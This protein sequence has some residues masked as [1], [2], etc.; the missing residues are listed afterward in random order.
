LLKKILIVVKNDNTREFLMQALTYNGFRVLAAKDGAG[1]LYKL[2]VCQPHLVILEIGDWDTLDRFRN[3]T[4][5][6]IIALTPDDDES[7]VESLDRGAD[8]FVTQPPSFGELA[9][10]IRA[11]LRRYETGALLIGGEY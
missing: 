2:G 5:A 1:G 8:F 4:A 6:P 3:L 11:L 7:G 10:R 9:A